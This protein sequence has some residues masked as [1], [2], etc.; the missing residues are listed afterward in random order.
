METP[1]ERLTLAFNLSKPS[2]PEDEVDPKISIQSLL[3]NLETLPTLPEIALKVLKLAKDPNVSINKYEELIS[4]DASL[5]AKILRVANSAYYG[6]RNKVSTLK[7]AM[8]MLG[9]EETNRLARAFSFLQS[10]PSNR[11]GSRFDFGRFWLH[12]IAVSEIIQGLSSRIGY[13]HPG[14]ASTGGL[15]HDMGVI[16][17]ASFYQDEFVEVINTVVERKADRRDVEREIYGMDHTEIGKALAERWNLPEKLVEIIRH[18]HDPEASAEEHRFDVT[19]AYLANR[20]ARYHGVNLMV[21]DELPLD[22]GDDPNWKF[23]LD[24]SENPSKLSASDL[25][26]SSEEDVQRAR[27]FHEMSFQ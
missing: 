14:E 6:L 22:L 23:L 18:H 4:R 9:L 17:A 24:R 13:E 26:A 3:E 5:T 8:V 20:I 16:V 21:E 15:L 27:E 12:N 11:A 7:M 10:F 2:G 1:P 19:L 25:I